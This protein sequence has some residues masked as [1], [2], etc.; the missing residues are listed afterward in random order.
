MLSI[1]TETDT[2]AAGAEKFDARVRKTL[3][4]GDDDPPVAYA[5]E[6]KF[7]GLAINL[8]YEGGDLVQAATRGDGETGEDVTPHGAHHRRRAQAAEGREG[9]VLEVRGEVFMRRDDFEALNARQR[10]SSRA[11][12]RTRR[13]SST[14][15][16]PPPASCASST[17]ATRQAARSASS[18]TA[19]ARSTAGRC[20]DA[21]RPARRRSTRSACR[22]ARCTRRSQGAAGL[23]DFHAAIAALRDSLPY[24]IDGVVYKVDD[25]ACRTS[26]ASS[27]ASRAGRSRRS[28]GAGEDDAAHG[29]RSA[30]RSH[31]QA[32]AVAKLEPVF[33]GG[34][35]VS[36]ATCTTCS[37]SAG[38][39]CASATP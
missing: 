15:A 14:R 12:R 39:A 8:R 5:A 35:T 13:P 3:G 7:D 33:V 9:A 25:R 2:T 36:N 31:R 34:T 30:G 22:R 28:T 16:T 10:S 1:D 11:A 37:R 6:M 4:L 17:R 27:R 24:D 21:D 19:S 29:D 32:H 18:P 26:S 20:R 23:V 38:R